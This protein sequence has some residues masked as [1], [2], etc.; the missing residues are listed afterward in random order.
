M[1]ANITLSYGG[2]WS[3]QSKGKTREEVLDKLCNQLVEKF[4]DPDHEFALPDIVQLSICPTDEWANDEDFVPV[5]SDELIKF[6][7]ECRSELAFA[8]MSYYS[9]SDRQEWGAF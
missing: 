6:E 1:L 3:T 4:A 9:P 2:E 5:T 7:R 8:E